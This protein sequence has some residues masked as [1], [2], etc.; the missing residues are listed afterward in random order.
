MRISADMHDLL[1]GAGKVF[2]DMYEL[3]AK[4]L[5]DKLYSTEGVYY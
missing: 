1:S 3:L 2:C 4:Q 5:V